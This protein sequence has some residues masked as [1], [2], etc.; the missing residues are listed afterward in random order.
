MNFIK[1]YFIFIMALSVI[2]GCTSN[3]KYLNERPKEFH[4]KDVNIYLKSF[5][6]HRQGAG[7]LTPI[8]SKII[9]NY[10]PQSLTNGQMLPILGYHLY[11]SLEEKRANVINSISMDISIKGVQT[12]IKNGPVSR[13]GY[14]WTQTHARVILTDNYTKDIIATFPIVVSESKFRNS[15]TGRQ[16]NAREDRRAMVQ[17]LEKNSKSLSS[18]IISATEEFVANYLKDQE[19]IRSALDN[20]L[21]AKEKLSVPEVKEDNLNLPPEIIRQLE[22]EE[23]KLLERKQ[24]QRII[25]EEKMLEQTKSLEK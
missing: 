12:F 5:S 19:A 13:Y 10:K 8:G 17:L 15:A 14:Y 20:D 23:Q 22:E 1:K 11:N 16:P 25:Y 9:Y 3:H 18:N 21:S 7:S 4:T 6:D 24:L 2:T